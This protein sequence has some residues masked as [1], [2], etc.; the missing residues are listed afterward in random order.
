MGGMPGRLMGVV[1][2]IPGMTGTANKKNILFMLIQSHRICETVLSH[3]LLFFAVFRC[4]NV[5]N[6]KEVSEIIEGKSSRMRWG[7]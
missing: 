3:Y 4:H 5:K 6:G 2:G 1:T 7:R